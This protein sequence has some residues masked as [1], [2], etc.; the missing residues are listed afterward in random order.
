MMTSRNDGPRRESKISLTDLFK[1]AAGTSINVDGRQLH[2]NFSL[3]VSEDDLI[4]ISFLR[5]SDRP[6]Q[7][8]AINAQHCHIQV[9]DTRARK[10]ALWLDTAP[11]RVELRVLKAKRGASLSIFNLWRDEKY[12]STMYRLNNAAMQI[13]AQQD[14]VFLVRCSDGWGEPDFNDLVFQLTHVRASASMTG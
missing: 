2:Q 7:G 13:D 11:E 8:L 4:V 3:Q 5:S 12:G 9:A 14:E 1:S 10:I 6:V